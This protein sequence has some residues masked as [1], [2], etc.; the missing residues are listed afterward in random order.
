M[1]LY[2]KK[3]NIFTGQLQWVTTPGGGSGP[4]GPTGPTG[5]TGPMGPTGP[6]GAGITGPQGL[7]GA[8][9]P[10]GPTGP[11]GISVT[12]PAGP[13]GS[14]GITGPTGPAG[15]TGP[16]GPQGTTL[17][18]TNIVS[19]DVG[20]SQV[21]THASDPDSKRQVHLLKA[22]E[23]RDGLTY[24]STTEPNFD[25]DSDKVMFNSDNVSLAP[26]MGATGMIAYYLFADN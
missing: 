2:K 23:I 26:L 13:T 5:A 1:G 10:Q 22:L 18:Q 3:V 15:I 19:L 7:T 4:T 6:T 8:T 11:T 12:G 20:E 21:I 14:Q 9:G 24:D 16:T 25:Y 17:I